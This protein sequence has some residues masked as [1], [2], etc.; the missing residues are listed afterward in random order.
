MVP[1]GQSEKV[2]PTIMMLQAHV[3]LD[4]RTPFGPFGFA[5]QVQPSL[6]RSA[7]GL[8]RVAGDTGTDDVLPGRRPPAVARNHMVQVQVLSLNFLPAILAGIA[9]ALENVVAGENRL[10]PLLLRPATAP[11]EALRATGLPNGK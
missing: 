6:A 5:D 8:E 3:H 10:I 9:G 1:I 2:F 11:P 7:I 4:E